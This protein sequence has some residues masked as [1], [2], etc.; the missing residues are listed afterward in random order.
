MDLGE[1]LQFYA[2]DCVGDFAF[3]EPFGF[4]ERDEDVRRITQINDM[5]LRMVTVAGLVPWF[6][7]LSS[8]WPFKLLLPREGD[9]VG[10]GTLFR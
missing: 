7:R 5:S 3:G 6:I 10:F 2:L 9:Q 1:K 8:K 4:L